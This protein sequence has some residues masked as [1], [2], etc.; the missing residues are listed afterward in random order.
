MNQAIRVSRLS[1]FSCLGIWIGISALLISPATA[2]VNGSGASPSND[3]DTVLNLPGDQFSFEGDIGGVA[4]ET[5][6]INVLSSGRLESPSA[7]FGSEV[8]LNGGT[9]EAPFSAENGSEINIIDGRLGFFSD[10]LFEIHTGSEVNI[11]GGEVSANV[12]AL[13]GSSVNING[14]ELEGSFDA[15]FGSLINISGGSF[16]STFGFDSRSFN[17][18]AG[19][20]VNIS[21]GNFDEGFDANFGS[22]VDISGGNFAVSYTHLTLPT[23][24]YV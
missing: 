13:S 15:F 8:N 12:F 2:Q 18:F 5:T 17:A 3:F 16:G 7:N 20:E 11:I 14:G 23:T 21:G 19:S 24:P 1:L 9:I 6:Q 4:G 10:G 22:L